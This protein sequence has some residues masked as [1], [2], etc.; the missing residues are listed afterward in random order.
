MQ[1][2]PYPALV[3]GNDILPICGE[4]EI[5]QSRLAAAILT[6]QPMQTYF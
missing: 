2:S 5:Y 4:I 3:F 1:L 6:L